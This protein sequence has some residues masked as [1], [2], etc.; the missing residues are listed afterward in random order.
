MAY[1]TLT[2]W[3]DVLLS[4]G[5]ILKMSDDKYFQAKFTENVFVSSLTSDEVLP[6]GMTSAGLFIRENS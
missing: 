6:K 5:F 2:K 3:Q 1:Q 4:G